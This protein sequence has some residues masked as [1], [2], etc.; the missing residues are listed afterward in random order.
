MQYHY[1]MALSKVGETGK[2]RDV[3]LAALRLSGDFEGVQ[4]AK[5]VLAKLVAIR[6]AGATG[7]AE[8]ARGGNR[9]N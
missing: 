1:G 3:L 2:S 7:G 6:R 5:R 8:G 4:E 9:Q